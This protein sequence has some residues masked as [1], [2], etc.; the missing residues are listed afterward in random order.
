[1][2][3]IDDLFYYFRVLPSGKD[4]YFVSVY[5]SD[6]LVSSY[7]FNSTPSAVR[8]ILKRFDFELYP[9]FSRYFIGYQ[10]YRSHKTTHINFYLKGDS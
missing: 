8:Y 6:T 1:M 7:Q 5:N 9:W 3:V 4:F 10:R 2:K